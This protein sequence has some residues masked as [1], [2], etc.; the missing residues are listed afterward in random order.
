MNGLIGRGGQHQ[1]LVPLVGE[2][3]G[4][5]FFG[6]L[7]VKGQSGYPF[8][9]LVYD[10]VSNLAEFVLQIRWILTEQLT[11]ILGKKINKL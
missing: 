3:S 1:E 6:Q 2:E 5:Y 11:N 9:Q 8:Y 7:V 4:M 10:G